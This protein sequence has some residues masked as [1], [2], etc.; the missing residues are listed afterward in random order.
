VYAGL[1]L[2]K[3]SDGGGRQGQVYNPS[4]SDAFHLIGDEELDDL[5]M[6][7]IFW[8]LLF[9]SQKTAVG[10]KASRGPAKMTSMARWGANVVFSSRS[11]TERDRD[12]SF[13]VQSGADYGST[14]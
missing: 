1:Q 7:V 5:H 14:L 4:R 11:E 10:T 6:V 8:F 13:L 12:L 2:R 9:Q 3:S